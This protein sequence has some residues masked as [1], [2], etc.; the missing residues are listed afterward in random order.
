MPVR[1]IT[2]CNEKNEACGDCGG[3]VILIVAP[4][5]WEIAD[6]ENAAKVVGESDSIDCVEVS[7][8]LSGHYC[9]KCER[10]CSLSFN[11]VG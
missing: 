3:P 8:E 11:H 2:V 9:P 6:P 5:V 4:H 7:E 1:H 10:L